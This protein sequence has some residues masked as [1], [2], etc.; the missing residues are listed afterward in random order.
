VIESRLV[1]VYRCG[2]TGGKDMEEAKETSRDKD[3]VYYLVTSRFMDVY[4]YQIV[5]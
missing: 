2:G 5:H 4:R 1:I 3:Y